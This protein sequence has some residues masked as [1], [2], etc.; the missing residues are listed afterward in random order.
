MYLVWDYLAIRRLKAVGQAAQLEGDESQDH[1]FLTRS[2]LTFLVGAVLIILGSRVLV[3]SGQTLAAGLGVPSAIIGFSVIAV[4]TSLPELVTGITAARKGVPELSLG[5]II[6]ANVLNLL[7]IIGLSGTIQPLTL[8]GFSQWYAFPW[9]AI[10]FVLVMLFIWRNG[11]IGP[12]AGGT[13]LT[14]YGLYLAG[15]VVLARI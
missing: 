1:E 11:N 3:T 2:L 12:R 10:F 8:D 15:L 9:M 6:G 14:L 5:N 4:G 7:L 13:L